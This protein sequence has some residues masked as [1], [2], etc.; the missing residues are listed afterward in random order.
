MAEEEQAEMDAKEGV[1][2]E[3]P[4]DKSTMN[5]QFG[6]RMGMIQSISL[7][8]NAGLMLYAHL[9]L[10]ATLV[11]NQQRIG[12]APGVTNTNTSVCSPA[13]NLLWE[14]GRDVNKSID[15]NFCARNHM[16]QDRAGCFLDFDCNADCFVKAHGFTPECAECFASI[17]QCSFDAGCTQFCIAD[18]ENVECEECSRPCNDVFY[19]CSGLREPLRTGTSNTSSSLEDDRPSLVGLS[20]KEVCNAQQEG[21]DLKSTTQFFDS[22]EVL[23]FESIRVSWNN[24]ARL[25]AVI[26]VLFSGIWPYAKNII[27]MLVWYMPMTAQGRLSALKWLRRLGKYTLVDVYVSAESNTNG[28]DI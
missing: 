2:D 10:S 20:N 17:P 13:D 19:E 1:S 24:D 9:G 4:A 6:N 15:S 7:I 16:F 8:L 25:V 12:T 28:H 11:A 14:G 23:F 21:V 5:V 18:G 26:I 3:K 22:Y 27:L